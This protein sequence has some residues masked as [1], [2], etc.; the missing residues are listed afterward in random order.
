[1]RCPGVG[2]NPGRTGILS[3]LEAMGA[4][5][6]LEDKAPAGGVEPVADVEVHGTRLHGVTVSGSLAVRSID[7]L[8][9]IAVLASQAEGVT[10]IRDAAELRNKETDRIAMLETGLRRLGVPCASTPDGLTVEGPVR[11]SAAH[12][13]AAGDHR[14][15]MA[16]AIAGALVPAGGGDTVIDNAD[17]AAVS[18]P[19]FFTDL[20]ILLGS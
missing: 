11:L 13:D 15:A 20:A 4:A 18:Y 19:G 9:I 10:E 2:V 6:S 14:F 1:M 16:W 17:A 5:V 8:P 7:E 12:L 3:V